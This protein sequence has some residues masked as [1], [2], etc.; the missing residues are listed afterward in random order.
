MSKNK[1]KN[2][3]NKD[4]G[5]KQKEAAIEL[6]GVV[7]EAVKNGFRVRLDDSSHT[8][9]CTLGGALR[10]NFIKVVPGDSVKVEVSPYD[11]GKGR[12]VFRVR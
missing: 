3:K 12:I 6:Q 5:G 9:L 1:N 7:T 8:I 4:S 11:L 2:K 10:K